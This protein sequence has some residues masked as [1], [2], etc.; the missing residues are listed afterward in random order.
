MEQGKTNV[1]PVLQED[2]WWEPLVISVAETVPHVA[3]QIKTIA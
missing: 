3:V 1:S 2:T